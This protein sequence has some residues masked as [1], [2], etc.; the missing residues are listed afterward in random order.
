MKTPSPWLLAAILVAGP[1]AAPA[2]P[3]S[4]SV[5]LK[6][7]KARVLE[8]P[9]KVIR[10]SIADP[11]IADVTVFSKTGILLGGKKTGSTSL[12][13]WTTRGRMD[14]EV[15]VR[16][17]TDALER[18]I[19]Q[20]V[21]SEDIQA[22]YANER[23][24]LTGK[25]HHASLVSLAGKIAEGFAVGPVVNLVQATL[26]PQIQVDVQ[27]VELVKSRGQDTGVSWGSL[28]VK[29]GGEVVFLK[30]LMTFTETAGPPFGGR[31]VLTFGQ[32]DRVAAELKMLVA[33]GRARVLAEPKLVVVSGAS[34]SVLVG[35]EFPVPITQTLGTV[36]VTWREYGVKLH[37][38]PQVIPDGRI[39]LR[40][41]PE[42]SALDYTNAIKVG[43]Y[44]LP[45]LRQRNAETFVVLGP[46]EGLGIGGLTQQVETETIEKFP[47]LGD[48]PILGALFSTTRR[49]RE[50]TELAILVSPRVVTPTKDFEFPRQST[51]GTLNPPPGAPS[52]REKAAREA[53]APG[54]QPKVDTSARATA[55]SGQTAPSPAE[56]PIPQA[57]RQDGSRPGPRPAV[58]AVS[59]ASPPSGT[60][61]GPATNPA[62]IPAPNQATSPLP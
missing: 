60:A 7:A 61:S 46:G 39:N 15:T 3:T 53:P 22:T 52:T 5:E 6:V 2:L 57:I 9:E 24:V 31:N 18:T 54:L 32:F 8:L 34:A 28:R 48:I 37:I 58:P 38:A 47:L 17:D 20:A 16:L 56:P 43:S 55:A 13:V 11:T 41:K 23:L 19:R 59:P 33:D 50:E 29:P 42:V 40:V 30:D 12:F 26:P 62:S 35:G 21:H 51:P 14:F 45:S 25:V 49:N 4:E 27:V 44:T 10:V 36:T 1:M